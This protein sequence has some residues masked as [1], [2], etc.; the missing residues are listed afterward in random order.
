MELFTDLKTKQLVLDNIRFIMDHRGL[1]YKDLGDLAG[2]SKQRVY[3]IFNAPTEGMNTST[4]DKISLSLGFKETS[5]YQEDF[6]QKIKN[7]LK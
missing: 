2:F 1:S 7:K 3:D 5:L 4:I 6:I